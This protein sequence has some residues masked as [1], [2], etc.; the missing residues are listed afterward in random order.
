MMTIC[1]NAHYLVLYKNPHDKSQIRYLAN[2]IFPEI[3]KFLTKVYEH[4]TQDPHSYILIHLH[5][6]T[7]EQYRVLSNIFPGEQIRFYLPVSI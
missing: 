3:S 7:P 5:P 4:A 2:Q 6:E 1:L